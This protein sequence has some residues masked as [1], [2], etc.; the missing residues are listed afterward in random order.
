MIKLSTGALLIALAIATP[1]W[2]QQDPAQP[3]TV[4]TT[5]TTG[6]NGE[7]ITRRE[8]CGA[9]EITSTVGSNR[10]TSSSNRSSSSN[11]SGHVAVT[12]PTPPSPPQQPTGGPAPMPSG[13]LGLPPPSPTPTGGVSSIPPPP[14]GAQQPWNNDPFAN[15]PQ[16]PPDFAR[17]VLYD[18]ANFRGRNIGVTQDT[19]D[20]GR[21]RFAD[22]A[23]AARVQAGVW[24]VCEDVNYGGRCVQLRSS[25]D[26]DALGIGD[27]ISSVRRVRT[28]E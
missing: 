23:S 27:T 3:C 10:S 2:A 1:A 11:S 20:L 8:G 18:R 5:T 6:P 28:D 14:T 7:T 12:T 15:I 13:G 4:T 16:P 22:I 21:R 26:L 9:V 17:I 24:E 25:T 19:P